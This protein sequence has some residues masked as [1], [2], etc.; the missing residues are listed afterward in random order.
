MADAG[1]ERVSKNHE[2]LLLHAPLGSVGQRNSADAICGGAP[3]R[4]L[5]VGA[6]G[7]LATSQ[8]DPPCRREFASRSPETVQYCCRHL[9]ILS[10]HLSVNTSSVLPS[11][12]LLSVLQRIL[13]GW[14]GGRGHN[15][16]EVL[17]LV[18]VQCV[19]CRD[20]DQE[21]AVEQGRRR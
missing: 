9:V 20:G 15:E 10:V 1:D 5:P 19:L 18:W 17:L 21:A 4:F 3:Y 13:T 7:K 16:Q 6:R 14:V 8:R 11:I 2:R 12:H